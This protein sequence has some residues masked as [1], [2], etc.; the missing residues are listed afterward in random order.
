MDILIRYLHLFGVIVLFGTL[1]IENMAIAREISREDVRNLA[2]VDALYGAAAGVVLIC[3]LALL[4]AGAKPTEFFTANPVFHI[5]MTLF[6]L[7]GLLSIYPT[8]FFVRNRKIEAERLA[9]PV[10]VI[11]LVRLEL[12]LLVFIPV[13]AFLMARGIGL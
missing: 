3:G 8:V 13:L 11:R 10:A 6:V 2:K 1:V 5:K 7:V 9:V 12:V 4:L